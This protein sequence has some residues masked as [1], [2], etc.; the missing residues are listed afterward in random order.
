M[1]NLPHRN[2]EKLNWMMSRIHH[3]KVAK[4]YKTTKKCYLS[5]NTHFCTIYLNKIELERAIY[6]METMKNRIGWCLEFT[7]KNWTSP[8]KPQK[9]LYLWKYTFLH[10]TSHN[11]IVLEWAIYPIKPIIIKFWHSLYSTSKVG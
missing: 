7:S 2:N 9:V 4:S 3:Q 1:G 8:T 10:S 11:K 6:P 5:E